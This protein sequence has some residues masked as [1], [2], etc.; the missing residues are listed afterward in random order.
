MTSRPPTI[1]CFAVKEEAKFFRPL[2][3]SLPNVK[4]VL[5]G[6]GQRNA[7]TTFRAVLGGPRPELVLTCGFAGGLNPVLTSGTVIFSTDDEP[8][9]ETALLKAGAK[10]ARFHCS[11]RVATTAAEKRRLYSSTGADAVEMESQ[12]ILAICRERK[13]PCAIVRVILDTVEEDLPLDFNSLMTADQR[14]DFRKLAMALVRAPG[15]VPVLIGL[16]KQTNS[17]ARRLAEALEVFLAN[18]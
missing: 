14:M 12:H 6:M 16:Q 9:L 15:K 10:S 1:V 18:T 4:I 17:A 3:A 7:E 13:L 11:S 5:T 2:A 8:G